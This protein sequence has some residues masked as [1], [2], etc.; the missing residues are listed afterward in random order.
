MLSFSLITFGIFNLVSC[1][2]DNFIPPKKEVTTL[3]DNFPAND[4]LTVDP[5]GNVYAANFGEFTA[6]GGNG[7][8]L[9]KANPFKK[10]F[11]TIVSGLTNPVG[12]NNFANGNVVKISYDNTKTVLATIEGYPSGIT[13]DDNDNIY[14]ANYLKGLV[15]KIDTA[16][17]L[18]VYAEDQRLFGG[19]GIDFDNDG[20]LIIGNLIT[21]DILSISPNKEV[22][23]IAKIPTVVEFSVIG[24]IAHY[25]NHIYATA[26]AEHVIY[27]VSLKTGEFEIFA[28]NGEAASIDG[29][30]LEASFNSPNGIT[31][32]PYRKILYVNEFGNKLRAIRL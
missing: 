8:T 3:F 5:F 6:T 9:L 28:G 4:G 14:I 32:D 17:N 1:Y 27:K 15:H 16:G 30:L 18:T 26:G 13:T 24:Y 29:P 2:G 22:K 25:K 19:V 11:D 12:T 31:I 20:N 7:T 23:L 21:G 10:E